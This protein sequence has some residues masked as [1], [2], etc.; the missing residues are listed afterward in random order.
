MRFRVVSFLLVPIT[1]ME[2]AKI[3]NGFLGYFFLVKNILRCNS[4]FNYNSNT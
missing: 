4:F 2:I 1:D 3:G